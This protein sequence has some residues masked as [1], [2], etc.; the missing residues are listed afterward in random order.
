MKKLSRKST[1]LAVVLALA[2]LFLISL[3]V[4]FE[5]TLKGP[6]RFVATSEWTLVQVEQ[7]K[8]QSNLMYNGTKQQSEINLFQFN[9]PDYVHLKLR[10][11]IFV[12]SWVEKGTLI[13][14][15]TSHEDE[16]R[17]AGLRGELHQAQANMEALRT[18]AKEALQQEMSQAVEYAK[19]QVAAYEPILERQKELYE[20]QLISEQQYDSARA[21][22]DLYKIQVDLQTA[23]LQAAKT[24]EKQEALE[25]LQAQINSLSNQLEVLNEKLS[26]ES[27]R[28]PISGIVVQPDRSVG[29]LVHIC[30]TD[31]MVIQM[32][33]RDSKIHSVQMG[34]TLDANAPGSGERFRATVSGISHNVTLVNLQPMFMVNAQ[35]SNP[36]RRLIHGMTGNMRISTGSTYWWQMLQQAWTNYRFNK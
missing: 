36:D 2:V 30:N 3:L 22:Y 13:A 27:I 5:T 14:N 12:G 8:V 7:D 18:G 15:L 23:R 17:L 6:G 33:V 20:K 29:E 4:K 24:G 26:A 10:Q 21:Q 16:I 35:L 9:R 31:T 11:G 28:T 1:G 34:M 25:I 32:P 19:A